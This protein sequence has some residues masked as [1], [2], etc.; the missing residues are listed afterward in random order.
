MNRPASLTFYLRLLL[1][2]NRFPS[3]I[4]VEDVHFRIMR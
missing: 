3:P 2:E 4:M 1:S